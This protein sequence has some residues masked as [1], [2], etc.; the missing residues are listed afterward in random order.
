VRHL[1][2]LACGV[3][4]AALLAPARAREDEAGKLFRDMERKVR[5]AKG[6][7]VTF[8]YQVGGRKAK[9]ELL[10]AQGNKARLKV[11]GH[12]EGKRKACFEL[13]SDGKRLKTKGARLYVH[14]SGLP[15]VEAGGQS[16]WPTPKTFYAVLGSTVSRGG[17]WFTVL[18]LP[19][20]RGGE[21]GE[22]IDPD[23]EG[24]KM[25]AYDFKLAGAAKVGGRQAR[26][27]RYRFGKG[28]GCRDDEEMTLW[29]DAKTLLPLRRSFVLKNGGARISETYDA[30]TLD[31]KVG[32]D[33]FELPK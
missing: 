25:H 22:E 31:P 9:G 14:P 26:V 15:V 28:G 6:F 2:T 3:L 24:S 8:T 32:A 20:L 7:A 11:I 4:A 30:F 21:G 5:A 1:A 23:A 29:I 19:Y 10:A 17:V 13:A 27:L 33:A 16:E 12:F 18:L